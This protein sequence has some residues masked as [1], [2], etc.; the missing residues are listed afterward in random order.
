[1][2]PRFDSTKRSTKLTNY[3][4][5]Q[6]TKFQNERGET[7]TDFVEIKR[8]IRE[9]YEQLYANGWYNLDEKDKFQEM[10]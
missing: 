10:T 7:T 6:I 3:K 4:K 8:T 9:C 1:M 5:M 2:K